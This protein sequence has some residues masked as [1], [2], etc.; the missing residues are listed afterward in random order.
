MYRFLIR[1]V[2]ATAVCWA[3]IAVVI[4]WFGGEPAEAGLVVGTVVM[5]MG[6][7]L[8]HVLWIT[9]ARPSSSLFETKG[10]RRRRMRLEAERRRPAKARQEDRKR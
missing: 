6:A 3:F 1:F 5:A 10:M 9:F 7:A 4:F 2:I 8:A